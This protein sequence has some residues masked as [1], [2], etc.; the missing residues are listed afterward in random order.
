LGNR[1]ARM[2]T[3]GLGYHRFGAQGQDIGAAACLSLAA[4]HTDVVAGLH[5]T[6]VLTFPP[7][8]RPLTEE[9]KAFL[10]RQ[11]RWR[12]IEGGYAH[13]QGTYPQTLAYGLTDSPAGLAAW[14]VDKFRA[15]SDC[16]GDVERRFTKDELLTNITLYWATGAIGSSFWPY[17]ARLHEGWPLPEGRIAVPTAYAAFPK[18]IVRPP[19]A[20]AERAFDI[21]RWTVFDRGGHFAALE[22]PAALAEDIR[23]FYRDLR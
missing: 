12:G 5:L 16:G 1:L 15:W 10:A 19:R 9:G 21:R 11:E 23:A 14:I 8:G 4:D 13:Q 22:Q 6:G 18:E 20:L 2:M 7:E 3:D 17:Y